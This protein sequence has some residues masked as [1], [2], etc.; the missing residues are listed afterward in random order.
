MM[1]GRDL[2]LYILENKLEDEPIVKDGKFVGFVTMGEA[3]VRMNVGEAT[4]R[5]WLKQGLMDGIKIGDT[6]YICDNFTIPVENKVNITMNIS[7]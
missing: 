7:Y 4:I 3:A 6:I 5:A 2:I 1:T